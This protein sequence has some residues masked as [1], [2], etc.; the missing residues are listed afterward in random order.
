MFMF[1][2]SRKKRKM[3]YLFVIVVLVL[4][5]VALYSFYVYT[6]TL[7]AVIT[8]GFIQMDIE[9]MVAAGQLTAV[10]LKSGC[11]ELSFY[12]SPDQ[13][14][15]I[16]DGMS[17]VTKFRPMTHDVFVDVIE[18][19]E[20]KPIMVKV[21]KLSDDTYFAELVLHRW[22]RF[23]IVDMRPSDALAIAVRTSIPIYVNEKLVTKVC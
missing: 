15:A 7:N 19:F 10:Q 12:I 20:I 6:Q 3:A 22:N 9:K 23:L 14:Y 13:A 18:G 2:R 16:S 1:V 17:K 4:T 8:E 5:V 21:T 11:S